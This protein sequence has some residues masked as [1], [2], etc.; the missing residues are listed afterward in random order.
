[1]AARVGALIRRDILPGDLV[2]HAKAVQDGF[3]E[4][5]IVE[6]LPFGGGIAQMAAVLA[7]T[8][9]VAVGHGIAPAPFRNPAALAMEWATLAGAFPG[10]VIA[11]VG[12]GVQSWMD[13][14]GARVASPLTLLEE[15]VVALRRLLAGE[16]VSV[17]GRYVSLDS[18]RL[19]F[20]P[21]PIPMVLAGVRGPKSLLLSGRVA[22]GTVLPEGWNADGVE[23]AQRLIEQGAL[24][25]GRTDPHHLTVFIWFFVGPLNE[26]EE[27]RQS[28]DPAHNWAAVGENA[29]DVA[30]QIQA[31]IDAGADSVVLSPLG[32]D[33]TQQLQLASAEI[34]PRLARS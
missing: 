9:N 3:D 31:V 24:E 12:H 30:Y 23:R 29:E 16:T 14:V 32:D 27:R 2:A 11:G 15:S 21:S 7:A 28:S 18:V 34:V 33:F 8:E 13:E 1:M 5:W 19:E 6:D 22:D 25:A 17:A 20:P 4:M 10:R 26:I